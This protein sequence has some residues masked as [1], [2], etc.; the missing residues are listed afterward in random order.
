MK[1]HS[2]SQISCNKSISFPTGPKHVGDVL[3]AV[4]CLHLKNSVFFGYSNLIDCLLLYS[5]QHATEP[6]PWPEKYGNHLFKIL[7]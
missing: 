7:F 3:K 5:Q 1:T 2:D 6:S 4:G